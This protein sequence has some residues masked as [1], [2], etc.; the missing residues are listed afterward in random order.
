MAWVEEECDRCQ[1]SGVGALLDDVDV[2]RVSLGDTDL[3]SRSGLV[4]FEFI[5]YNGKDVS[6]DGLGMWNNI[7]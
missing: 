2:F 6:I 5:Y 1:G 7:Q 4:L 3:K